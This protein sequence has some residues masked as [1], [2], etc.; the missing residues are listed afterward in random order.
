MRQMSTDQLIETI[1][2]RPTVTLIPTEQHT[3]LTSAY[4]FEP[5]MNL[6]YMRDQQITTAKGIVMGHLKTPQR[7][8]ETKVMYFA[9]SK[10]GTSIMHT[11]TALDT[12]APTMHT[13]AKPT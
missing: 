6:I 10:L 2:I 1:M 8:L 3:G 11:H 13:H 7:R 4:S 9:F 12:I 5:L